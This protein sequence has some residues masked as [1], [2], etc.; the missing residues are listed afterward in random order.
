MSIKVGDRV[1]CINDTGHVMSMTGE[2]SGL[3]K[4]RE[5]IVYGILVCPKCGE[6]TYDVGFTLPNEPNVTTD[7]VCFKCRTDIKQSGRVWYASSRRFVKVNEVKEVQYVKLEVKIE[8][9]CLN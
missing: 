2:H 9:P 7:M 8:E 3:K 5:Y 6:V 4:G 1:L